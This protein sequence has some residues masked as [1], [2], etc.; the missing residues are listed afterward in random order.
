MTDSATK[1]E[2]GGED[3]ATR[4]LR[5]R[6]RFRSWHRGTREADL[7]L[8]SFADAH[9]A[10]FDRAMLEEYDRLLGVAD[11]DLYN[12]MSGREAIPPDH[13]G[14]VMHLLRGHRFAATDTGGD[15]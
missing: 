10:T 4:T 1:D 11:P 15:R 9:L 12:W 5:R 3:E 6:L 14:P 8:G 2:T 7:L 13:D